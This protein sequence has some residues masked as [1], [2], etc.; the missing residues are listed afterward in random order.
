MFGSIRA[1]AM[2]S[3]QSGAIVSR[4]WHDI[5]AHFANVSLDVYIVMPDHVH[6][7]I[8]IEEGHG[9]IEGKRERATLGQMVAFWKYQAAKQIDT[10]GYLPGTQ[11]W[12]RN[13]YERVL[14]DTKEIDVVRRY[15][16]TNV[17]RS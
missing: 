1:G 2:Q 8:V 4:C 5:A 16:T 13:Y 10:L 9:A 11:V 14:R 7:I 12:Q 17:I 3:S 15:I 6:G